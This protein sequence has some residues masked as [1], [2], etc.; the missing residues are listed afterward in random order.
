MHASIVEI[1]AYYKDGSLIRLILYV[2]D[3]LYFGSSDAIE[4]EFEKSVASRF[5]LDRP[6]EIHQSSAKKVLS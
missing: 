6:N 1:L 2:D 3:C 5:N 4:K